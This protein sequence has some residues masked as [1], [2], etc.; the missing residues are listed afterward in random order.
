MRFFPENKTT[1]FTT[2]LPQRIDLQGR[3]EVALTEIQFPT[4][5][6]H[7]RPGEGIIKFINIEEFTIGSQKKKIIAKKEF[8][9]Y[10]RSCELLCKI[11]GF[12]YPLAIWRYYRAQNY[13]ETFLRRYEM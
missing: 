7:I 13:Y 4:S 12:A 9:R 5:F 1:C 3:W 6:L 2:E 10:Y 11:R 8:A